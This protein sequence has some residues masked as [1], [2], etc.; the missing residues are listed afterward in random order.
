MNMLTFDKTEIQKQSKPFIAEAVFAVETISANQQTE[1]QVKAKQLLDRLFPLENGSHQDVTSYVVDYRH[2]MAYFKD[3]QHSGLKHPK[4]FVAYMGEKNDP[5]SILFRDGSG[6]HL[7]VMFGCHKGTGCIELVEIDDIQLESCTTFGQSPVE[8]TTTM[9][10]ETIA[11]MRHWIS[12]IQGDAKGKPKACSED[13]EFRA[14]SGED[15]C[16]NYCYQL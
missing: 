14:K 5:D 16:L 1:K 10:E 2:I 7:E 12:L 6:S 4:Q 13:K 8:A 11:A 9:R 15:Y 3:G